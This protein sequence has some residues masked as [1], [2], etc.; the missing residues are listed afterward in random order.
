[1]K[2]QNEIACDNW[3]DAVKIAKLLLKNDYVVMLSRE[4]EL[5]IINYEWSNYCDRNNVVFQHL[6]TFE[7][8]QTR[9]CDECRKEEDE[10]RKEHND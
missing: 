3:E 10:W 1:M 2:P 4:E 5:T 9:R 8:E 7:M 6:D